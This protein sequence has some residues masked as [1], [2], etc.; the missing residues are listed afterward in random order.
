MI[1]F[2]NL[3][4]RS[5]CKKLKLDILDALKTTS[6]DLLRYF[7]RLPGNTHKHGSKTSKRL[8][9]IAQNTEAVVQRCSAACNFIKKRDSGTSVFL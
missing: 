2:Q 4:D 7:C 3:I 5:L 1:I 8:T 9:L 6:I